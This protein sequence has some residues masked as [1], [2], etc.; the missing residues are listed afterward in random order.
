MIKVDK[1]EKFPIVA[2]LLDEN[3]GELVSGRTVYYDVRDIYDN[4]LTPVLSG[5][6]TESSITSGVYKTEL[7]INVPG[8]YI[9]Y[10]TCSGFVSNTE[11]IVVREHHPTDLYN[12]NISVEE[13]Q[14]T[15]A[16]PTA[17]Q[18]AR[19]VPLNKTDYLISRVKEDSA[20][21]WS[22]SVASGIVWAHYRSDTDSVP[23]IMGAEY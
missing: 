9:C 18:L 17:S 12:Y 5:T 23:Y 4:V 8:T 7:S 19:K 20:L 15:N 14:R 10:S 11:D 21:D 22:N 3:T 1:A 2:S 13:V 16:V 6:L